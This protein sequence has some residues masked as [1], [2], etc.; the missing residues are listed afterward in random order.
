MLTS[1]QH[2]PYGNGECARCIRY[3]GDLQQRERDQCGIPCQE[4]KPGSPL[5]RGDDGYDDDDEFAGDE[6]SGEHSRRVENAA[7][8][9]RRR[10]GVTTGALRR[11]VPGDNDLLTGDDLAARWLVVDCAAL[12]RLTADILALI[13]ATRPPGRPA[14]PVILTHVPGSSVRR[15]T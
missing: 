12:S 5:K 10:T 4:E 15:T 7:G 13:L 2:V 1:G 9:A 11:S 3:T 8:T 14:F 6:E